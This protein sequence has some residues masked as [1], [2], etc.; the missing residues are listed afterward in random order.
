MPIQIF[1][2][3]TA[4][5]SV[6]GPALVAGLVK[7]FNQTGSQTLITYAVTA[8]GIYEVRG[9]LQILSAS[10][11]GD[12][13]SVIAQYTDENNVSQDSSVGDQGWSPSD[14]VPTV[15]TFPPQAF[16]CK[17]GTNLLVKLTTA[18][19]DM[20]YDVAVGVYKLG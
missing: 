3:S 13:V 12:V 7:L 4:G 1:P 8:D 16:W 17:S 20:S 5:G 14:N 6:N 10:T 11:G 9:S 19:T 15:C 2:Q 18:G